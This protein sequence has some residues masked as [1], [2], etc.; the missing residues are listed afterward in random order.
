MWKWHFKL[1]QVG[2]T[3]KSSKLLFPFPRPGEVSWPAEPVFS[4]T[5][6]SLDTTYYGF[7]LPIQPNS[8][9]YKDVSREKEKGYH[10]PFRNHSITKRQEITRVVEEKGTPMDCWWEY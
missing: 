5:E 9:G 3:N 6:T 4:T 1:G 10:I 8:A 2:A 7:P